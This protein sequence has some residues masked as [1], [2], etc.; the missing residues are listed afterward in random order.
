MAQSRCRVR[1]LWPESRLRDRAPTAN[2]LSAARRSDGLYARGESSRASLGQSQIAHLACLHQFGHCA[3]RIFNG[4][5]FDQR[6][7]DSKDRSFRRRGASGWLRKPVVTYSGLPFTPR[8]S[9]FGSAHVAELGGEHHFV[10]AVRIAR[11]TSSSFC[12]SRT[13]RRYPES[14][15][16]FER[17][18]DGGDGFLLATRPIKFRHSHATQSDRRNR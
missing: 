5:V 16:Q 12:R 15:A 13:C 2:I 14:A 1:A 7:A 6:D 17:P 8:N 18:M 10:A 4:N 11:P 3:H 9:P